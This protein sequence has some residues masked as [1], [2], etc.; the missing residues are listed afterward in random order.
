VAQ[1]SPYTPGSIARHVPGREMQL[2]EIGERLDYML[3]YESAIPRIRIDYA[4]RGYGKTSL[5][6][7][8]TRNAEAAGVLTLRLV[9]GETTLMGELAGALDHAS[10]TWSPERGG[11]LRAAL[12]R[13][14]VTLDVGVPGVAHLETTLKHPEID[15]TREPAISSRDFQQL[16]TTSADAARSAGHRGLLLVVD[17][18]Q[19]ADPPGL[20]ALCYGWQR[21]QETPNDLP[22]GVIAAALPNI[23]GVLRQHVSNSERLQIRQLGTLAPGASAAALVDPARAQNVPWNPDALRDAVNYADGFPY[24]LQLIGDQAWQA[25]GR[26]DPGQPITAQHVAAARD[27]ITADLRSQHEARWIKATP[28]Q[29]HILRVMADLGGDH[30]VSRSQLVDRLGTA[31]RSISQ[32]RDQLIADGVIESAARGELSFT[33]TGFAQYVQE[34]SAPGDIEA[35]RAAELSDPQRRPPRHN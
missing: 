14:D 34:H 35:D 30:P 6:A 15:K 22:A 24:T 13:L 20:R 28:A 5:L 29:R 10:G 11:R 21:I 32:L 4:P 16:I 8:V 26:P 1:P 17:E 19:D 18:L 3:A 31:T 25:A 2:A 7:E 33:A 23:R 9:G 12:R 27:R